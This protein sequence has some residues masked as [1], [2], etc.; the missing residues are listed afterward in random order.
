MLV[1]SIT[2]AYSQH[3]PEG[4]TKDGKNVRIA[5][6][7]GG[8]AGIALLITG[9]VIFILLQMNFSPHYSNL[10]P[11]TSSVFG[12]CF[13]SGGCLALGTFAIVLGHCGLTTRIKEFV[14][15]NP[16]VTHPEP[17]PFNSHHNL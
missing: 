6:I 2:K 3:G 14:N 15:P 9:I 16:P 10:F 8:I 7:A 12:G 5:C 17:T 13:A 1:Q 4:L 11:T